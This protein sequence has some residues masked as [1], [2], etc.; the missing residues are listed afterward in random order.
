MWLLDREDSIERGTFHTSASAASG[1]FMKP[2]R[3]LKKK[4]KRS[5]YRDLDCQNKEGAVLF[6]DHLESRSQK[7]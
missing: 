7:T 1:V 2:Q 6:S 4:N 3:M 5:V